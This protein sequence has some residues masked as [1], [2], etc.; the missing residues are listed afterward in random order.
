[1]PEHRRSAL[2][3]LTAEQQAFLKNEKSEALEVALPLNGIA[4]PKTPPDESLGVTA[5]SASPMS[6]SERSRSLR[7]V[8]LRLHPEIAAQLRRVSIERSLDYEVPYTQQAIVEDALRNWLE[9]H[10]YT[11]EGKKRALRS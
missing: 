7:S 2:A 10:G 4:D 6:P 5:M 3:T 9:A 11:A 1:M 8:T